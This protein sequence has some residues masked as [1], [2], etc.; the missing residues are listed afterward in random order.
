M[1]KR[2]LDNIRIATKALLY[3]V[4][5]QG[6][7]VAVIV[8]SWIVNPVDKR[9]STVDP[10]EAPTFIAIFL[11]VLLSMLLLLSVILP[12]I[13]LRREIQNRRRTKESVTDLLSEG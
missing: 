6:V 9:S 3:M 4:I 11:G 12:A 10:G 8:I 7:I 1:T 5:P 2:G 13:V